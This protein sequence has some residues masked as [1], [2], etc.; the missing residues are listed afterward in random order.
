[1]CDDGITHEQYE[2][3]RTA[4]AALHAAAARIAG[5]DGKAD[6]A[7]LTALRQA[8]VPDPAC[9]AIAAAPPSF[10]ILMKPAHRH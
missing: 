7:A 6:V 2:R 5:L 9:F 10:S 3:M 8:L 4:Y 1:M